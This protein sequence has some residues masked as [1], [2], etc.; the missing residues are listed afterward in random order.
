[1]SVRDAED[2]AA[3]I[4][5][6]HDGVAT[7]G[8]VPLAI[9]LDNRP[10]NHTAEVD[11]A[12]GDAT[13]RIRATAG[14]PQNKAHVE[15]GFGLFQQSVPA[16]D[17]HATSGRDLGRRILELVA[18][19]WART[20]NH[21]P[22]ADRGGRSRVE[23]YNEP[24]TAEQI[25]E[26][27]AALEERRRKQELA[28]TTAEARQNPVVRDILD[29]AFARLALVDPERHIRLAIARYPID[30]VIE[31]IATFE[32]KLC[33]GTLPAGVDARYLL[34]IVRNIGDELEG[35]AIADELLRARLEARDRM[36]AP[37]VIARAAARTQLPNLRDRVLH[38]VDLALAAVRGIDRTFWLLAAA[39]EI[40]ANTAGA[41]APLVAALVRRIHATH[42]VPRC[43][44]VDAVRVIV[45]K[46]VPLS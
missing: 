38:Y 27:R 40:N 43:E 44:R 1:M 29:A 10:S 12:L 39:E 42:R 35:V 6:L 11:A 18:Q 15:G 45:A 21:R 14:R 46:V 22:R 36:L 5:A 37:L 24:R 25:D 4:E 23:L 32:T 33:M 31:G 16:L 19:T 30:A 26:A 3:V 8:E 13:I 28:R 9:L 34:G 7:T 41:P 20:L 2:S 17:L